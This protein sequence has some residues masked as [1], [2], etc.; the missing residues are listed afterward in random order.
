MKSK[1]LLLPVVIG[2]LAFLSL[3]FTALS[4][5]VV[6]EEFN[7]WTVSVN[8]DFGYGCT[9]GSKA[10]DPTLYVGFD[11][12]DGTAF[13]AFGNEKWRSIEEGKK[14]ELEMDFDGNEFWGDTFI[15]MKNSTD[16]GI[17]VLWGEATTGSTIHDWLRDLAMHHQLNIRY[18]DRSV[19]SI[20][21]RGTADAIRSLLECRQATTELLQP[22][23]DSADPFSDSPPSNDDP[24]A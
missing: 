17:L 7:R 2:T 5:E 8:S 3:P 1:G 20:S 24:F 14:Y 11:N 12:S 18:G 4:D 23:P 10:Q 13:V 9:I 16:T 21:L 15:G 22:E 6:W 19:G